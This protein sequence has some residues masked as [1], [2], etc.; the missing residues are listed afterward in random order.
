MRTIAKW[1]EK[2]AR[3]RFSGLDRLQALAAIAA[4]YGSFDLY[5]IFMGVVV[6][7]HNIPKLLQAARRSKRNGKKRR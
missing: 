4:I 6:A 7:S 2:W 5:G 1:A 3:K